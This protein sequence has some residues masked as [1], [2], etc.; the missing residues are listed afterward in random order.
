MIEQPFLA[1]Q[2][3]TVPAERAVRTDYAM[4]WDSDTNH[5]RAVG[6]PD[7]APCVAIA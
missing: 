3:T 5:V 2:S 4:A 1:P 7:R 6:A